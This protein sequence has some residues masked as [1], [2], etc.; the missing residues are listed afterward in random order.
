[1]CCSTLKIG[2]KIHFGKFFASIE[3]KTFVLALGTI[4]KT[5]VCFTAKKSLLCRFFVNT[6]ML[7]WKTMSCLYFKSMKA[8]TCQGCSRCSLLENLFKLILQLTPATEKEKLKGL[9]PFSLC[10]SCERGR[11]SGV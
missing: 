6:M 8:K 7:D 9:F 10:Q 11:S 3:K 1:M 4:P 2:K 5:G